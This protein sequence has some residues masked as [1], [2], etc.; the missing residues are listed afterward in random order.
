M[1]G[2]SRHPCGICCDRRLRAC[3][4]GAAAGADSKPANSAITVNG[5][6]HIGADMIRSYF[7]PA[8]GGRLD[9]DAL[10]AALKRL[11][12]TGLFKDVKI[13]RDGDRV[14][15]TVV[16]NPTIGVL[17]FEGNKKIKDDDLK[18]AM[19]SKDKRPAVARIR[20][21]RRRCASSMLYRQ[22]GYYDVHV[23][24]KTIDAKNGDSSRVN[25]VFEIK[26][27]DKLAVRQIAF[28]GNTAFSATKLKAVVK[29]GVTNP[30]SFILDNDIYDADRIEND[31]DLI[32][33]FYLAHGYPD[34]AGVG[35][36][37]LRRGAERR[38][39]DIQDR[40][41]PALPL[42]QD[43]YRVEPPGGRS[44]GAA[45]GPAYAVRRHF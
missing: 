18:K 3:R 33:R 13:S 8:P 30:L 39:A 41:R 35:V 20:A 9:A 24:P 10:D 34:D 37:E 29:T 6:R 28:V 42:R 40:R 27:G 31:R 14:V 21:R 16:E 1:P 44:G 15:V 5:N 19:Q 32:R 11:Y 25:L 12:A 43:R 4:G 45:R 17:A 26:E 7:H 38:R 22:H 23:V 2:D 36:G